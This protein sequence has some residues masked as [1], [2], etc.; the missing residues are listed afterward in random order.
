MIDNTTHY[1]VLKN[2]ALSEHNIY[3]CTNILVY[4][5]RDD[6]IIAGIHMWV[7]CVIA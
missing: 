4:V 1:E 5:Q 6:I 7:A 3:I 2:R